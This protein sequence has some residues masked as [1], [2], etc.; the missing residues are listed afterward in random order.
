MVQ[1]HAHMCTH[2]THPNYY[3]VPPPL[4]IFETPMPSTSHKSRAFVSATAL[5]KREGKWVRPYSSI[6]LLVVIV[7]FCYRVKCVIDSEAENA[8]L[9]CINL[10]CKLNGSIYSIKYSR[11]KCVIQMNTPNDLRNM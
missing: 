10:N 1:C 6:G 4:T 8:Y 3:Y 7:L 5:I 9:N 11:G 2:T